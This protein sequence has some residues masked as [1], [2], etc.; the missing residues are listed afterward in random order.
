MNTK[1]MIIAGVMA[2][3]LI[4]QPAMAK[5]DKKTKGNTEA[6]FKK[7]DKNSDGHLSLEEF[8]NRGKK[9]K[10]LSAKKAKKAKKK[11][12]K[13]D[14]NKDKKVSLEEFLA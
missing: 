8:S 2:S 4:A 12:K 13:A 10:E 3:I 5:K 9:G 6:T 7:I 1:L 14:A 11:F